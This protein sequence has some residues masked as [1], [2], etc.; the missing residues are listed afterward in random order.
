MEQ[1]ISEQNDQLKK[2]QEKNKQTDEEQSVT[3]TTNASTLN[4]PQFQQQNELSK[5][6]LAQEKLKKLKKE[7]KDKK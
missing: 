5:K 7:K 3:V 2:S 6:S 1:F 4:E